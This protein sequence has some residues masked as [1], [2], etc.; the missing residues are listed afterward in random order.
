ML[1]SVLSYQVLTAA[2]RPETQPPQ[3]APQPPLHLYRFHS[4]EFALCQSNHLAALSPECPS[5]TCLETKKS[6]EEHKINTRSNY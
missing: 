4:D 6:E 3:A 1:S 2:S 5:V